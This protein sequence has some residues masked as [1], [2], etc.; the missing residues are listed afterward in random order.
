MK[1][2]FLLTTLLVSIVF[3]IASAQPSNPV[4]R[5]QSSIIKTVT[6][7]AN[8]LSS[9]EIQS[10]TSKV[11][12][13]ETKHG[14][15]IGIVT[16]KSARGMSIGAV[17]DALLNDYFSGAKNGSIALTIVMDTREWHVST[18]A[19]MKLRITNEAG[20]PF[21]QERFVSIMSQDN[22]Y[23]AFDTYVDAIDQLLT[24]YEQNE[25]PYDPSGGF[26]PLA[27]MSA[28]FLAIII[29]FFFRSSLISAMSNV[30]A[31]NEASDYLNRDSVKVFEARDMFLFM[32]VVRERRGGG[33]SGGG[34]HSGGGGGGGGHF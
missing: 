5:G 9:D 28:V 10:L 17:A 33:R 24:Y 21:L 29:A 15:R 30:H 7:N 1:K 4:E 31:A 34:G 27:A 3:S 32:N 6:D 11:Q 18:D 12:S 2:F 26:N 25:T 20:I 13:I 22:Y 8:L 23:R 14:I 16:M 19:Q